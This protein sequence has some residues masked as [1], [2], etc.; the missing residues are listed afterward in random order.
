MSGPGPNDLTVLADL[1]AYLNVTV[2]TDDVLLQRL[3]TSCSGF[4]QA[5]M[6][7]VIAI[8]TYTETRDGTDGTRLY[9]RNY[10]I[11]AVT[12]VSIDQIAIASSPNSGQQG[13]YFNYDTVMLNGYTFNRGQSNVVIVYSAGYATV[14]FELAQACIEMVAKRYVERTRIGVVSKTLAGEVITYSIAD[15]MPSTKT[16]MNDYKRVVP[17]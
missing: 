4:M 11:T 14:P 8:S 2:T 12:S 10:P 1:K 7:R 15:M 17:A 16:I 5:W 13:F 3:I 6:N 9:M